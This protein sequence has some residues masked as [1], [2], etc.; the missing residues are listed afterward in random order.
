MTEELEDLW[1]IDEPIAELL[2]DGVPAWIEQDIAGNTIEAI[3]QGGCESG[4]YMPAVTYWQASETMADHGDDVL[5]FLEDHFGELPQPPANLSWSGMACF[6]LS[7]AVEQWAWAVHE[8]LLEAANAA[9]AA[10]EDG[11]ETISD[12]AQDHLSG[13]QDTKG[14]VLPGG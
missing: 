1:Q 12:A 11:Y 7:G 6:Y 10:D 2:D 13:P 3:M 8:E 9:N 5:Q 14:G 4:A